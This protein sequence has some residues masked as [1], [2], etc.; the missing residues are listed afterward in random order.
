MTTLQAT[1][2][3]DHTALTPLTALT[4]R[5]EHVQHEFTHWSTYSQSNW[6]LF[7]ANCTVSDTRWTLLKSN[8]E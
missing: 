8:R 6:T 7:K 1:T 3:L 5:C 4:G 2:E